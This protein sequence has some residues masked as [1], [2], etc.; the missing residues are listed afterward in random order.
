[1]FQITPNHIL[2]AG[3]TDLQRNSLL[4]TINQYNTYIVYKLAKV[5]RNKALSLLNRFGATPRSH[6]D[7]TCGIN[8]RP[9]DL[10]KDFVL[11]SNIYAR[12]PGKG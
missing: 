11:Y 8:Q 12:V 10:H 2:A 5:Q 1:M 3:R 6:V 9:H 7:T 4:R